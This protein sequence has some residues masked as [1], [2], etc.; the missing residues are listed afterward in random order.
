MIFTAWPVP[1]AEIGL[2]TLSV[3]AT[4]ALTVPLL[5][6]PV[7]AQVKKQ[8]APM[9]PALTV[10]WVR[11]SFAAVPTPTVIARPDEVEIDP[12]VAVTPAVSTLLS[13]ITPFFV[14]VTVATPAVKL[15]AVAVPKGTAVPLLL[16]T[17]GAAPLGLAVAPAKVRLWAPV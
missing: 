4:L 2:P 16:A 6:R 9:L 14:D 13:F 11:E 12:S 10:T 8:P 17:V 7:I 3:T 15:I 5:P 1:S